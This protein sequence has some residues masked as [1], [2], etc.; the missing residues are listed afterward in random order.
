MSELEKLQRRIDEKL[1]V[2]DERQR[3]RQNHSRELMRAAE[4]AQARYTALAD[5]LMES[6]VRPRMLAVKTRLDPIAASEIEGSRHTCSLR[7]PHSPRFPANVGIQMGVTR[8]GDA[9]TLIVQYDLEIRPVFF[10]FD[11]SDELKFPIAQVDTERVCAWVDDKLVEFV[12]NYL[13][14]E[15]EPHY[16]DENQVIDP[17]CGMT[18][19][20][21]EA[22]AVA[23][24]GGK[25]Y[26]F[27][28]ADCRDRFLGDPKRYLHH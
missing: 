12:E 11:G 1:A 4:E 2:S 28:V 14:L 18:V 13:R 9:R 23:E 8:D 21:T 24:Y 10:P 26:W 6:V 27:C 25:T 22:P 17:V 7:L 20:R 15:I 3:L 16:Q 5:R 19:N